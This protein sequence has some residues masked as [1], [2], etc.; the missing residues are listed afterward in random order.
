MWTL[1]TL[2]YNIVEEII[3]KSIGFNTF[4]MNHNH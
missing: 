3:K 1:C 4:Y 2:Q